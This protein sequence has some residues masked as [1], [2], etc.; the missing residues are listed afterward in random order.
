LTYDV[1]ERPFLSNT[2]KIGAKTSRCL[3][4][5][6]S[7]NEI[8]TLV[9]TAINAVNSA[10]SESERFASWRDFIMVMVCFHAGPRIA[11]L[12]RLKIINV[13]L[14]NTELRIRKGKGDKD[15]NVR[16][17]KMLVPALRETIAGAGQVGRVR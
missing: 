12:C 6:L 14:N 15:R 10:V 9:E 17:G 13:D 7:R 5:F 1:L 2:T 4:D 11:E 16:F 8:D 3:P